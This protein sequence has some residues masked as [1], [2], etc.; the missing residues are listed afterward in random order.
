MSQKLIGKVLW[1][2]EKKGFG[3]IKYEDKEYFAH[4]TEIKVSTKQM[5]LHKSLS[6][7]DLESLAL[8]SERIQQFVQ[9]GTVVKVIVVPQK[10][11]NVVV[12][13]G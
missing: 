5:N 7:D 6:K 8:D 3:V 4:H 11:V 12:K 1:F 13:G 2:D 10:L 9:K